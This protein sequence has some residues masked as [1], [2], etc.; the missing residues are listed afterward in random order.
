MPRRRGQGSSW[1]ESLP[2]GR[3]VPV[4]SVPEAPSEHLSLTSCRTGAGADMS[5]RSRTAMGQQKGRQ[6]PV[7]RK[8]ASARHAPARRAGYG[9]IKMKLHAAILA[10]P[11]V[12]EAGEVR[13]RHGARVCRGG[14]DPVLRD[15]IGINASRCRRS[16]ELGGPPGRGHSAA[17]DDNGRHWGDRV[18]PYSIS[19]GRELR[20][21]GRILRAPVGGPRAHP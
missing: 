1:I 14:P 4:P 9:R 17:V 7:T 20:V 2:P 3:H 5:P 18:I 16:L 11:P 19:P 21:D 10:A 13:G 12:P 8:R 15:W 6:E